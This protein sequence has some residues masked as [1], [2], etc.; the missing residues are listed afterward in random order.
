[1]DEAFRRPDPGGPETHPVTTVDSDRPRRPCR[2]PLACG[3]GVAPGPSPTAP[4]TTR[5]DRS[6]RDGAPPSGGTTGLSACGAPR[7]TRVRR[8][9]RA[10]PAQ[11]ALDADGV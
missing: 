4:D 2:E 5:P 1:M 8:P 3:K 10:R 7:R 9:A 11:S 6:G